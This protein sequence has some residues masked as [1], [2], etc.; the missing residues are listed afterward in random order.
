LRRIAPGLS[1]PSDAFC[2]QDCESI[3]ERTIGVWRRPMCSRL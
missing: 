3:G 1:A 2:Y